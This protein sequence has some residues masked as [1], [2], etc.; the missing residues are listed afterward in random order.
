MNCQTFRSAD[1]NLFLAEVK[2]FEMCHLAETDN[3]MSL[4]VTYRLGGA[5]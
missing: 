2:T 4:N 5:L 3:V 1:V